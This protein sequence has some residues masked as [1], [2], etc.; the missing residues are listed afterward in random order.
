MIEFRQELTD[1]QGTVERSVTCDLIMT[2]EVKFSLN[3][4]CCLLGSL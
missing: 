4:E 1:G 2:A 3:V